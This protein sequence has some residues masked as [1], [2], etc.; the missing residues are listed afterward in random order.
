[1]NICLNQMKEEVGKALGENSK[2]ILAQV[3]AENFF[4]P[5]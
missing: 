5:Y 2:D 1:M 4:R 3:L